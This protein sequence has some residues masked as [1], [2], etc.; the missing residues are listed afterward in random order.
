LSQDQRPADPLPVDP[1]EEQ[2]LQVG[3]WA[4]QQLLVQADQALRVQLQVPTQRRDQRQAEKIRN[5]ARAATATALVQ[6]QEE[7]SRKQHL[8]LQ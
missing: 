5:R 3:L 6:T 4:D 8:R 2:A 7:M 1:A